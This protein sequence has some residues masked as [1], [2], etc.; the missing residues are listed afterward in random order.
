MQL[1]KINKSNAMT[2][3]VTRSFIFCFAVILLFGFS[4]SKFTINIDLVQM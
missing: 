3:A 4:F 1:N 2:S